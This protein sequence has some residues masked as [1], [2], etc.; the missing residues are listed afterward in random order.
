MPNRCDRCF[1]TSCPLTLLPVVSSGGAK[2]PKLPLPGDGD[3][4]TTDAT[5]SRQPDVVKPVAGG[6]VQS[7]RCHNSKYVM[8][9]DWIDDSYLGDRIHPAISGRTFRL[10]SERLLPLSNIS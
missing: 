2:V 6:L 10:G 1:A 8:T 7:R 4:P 5:F 9:D 3:D